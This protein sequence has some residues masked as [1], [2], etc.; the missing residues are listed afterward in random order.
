MSLCTSGQDSK[1]FT[2]DVFIE[3]LPGAGFKRNLLTPPTASDISVN[4]AHSF[5]AV[6]SLSLSLPFD[7]FTVHRYDLEM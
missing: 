5:P 3:T 7:K 2:S 1:S 4:G 6:L